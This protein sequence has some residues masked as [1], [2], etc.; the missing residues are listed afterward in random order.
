MLS[1]VS[2]D[3]SAFF[4]KD[5]PEI[6]LGEEEILAACHARIRISWMAEQ[7]AERVREKFGVVSM[8][9]PERR[10]HGDVG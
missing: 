1:C 2:T 3:R 4:F 10:E 5:A 6:H 8:L 7:P 9:D